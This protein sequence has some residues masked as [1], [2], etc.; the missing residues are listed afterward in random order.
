MSSIIISSD[1]PAVSVQI[2]KQ[3]VETLEYDYLSTPFLTQVAEKFQISE[4]ELMNCVDRPFSGRRKDLKKQELYLNYIRSVVLERLE[5]DHLVCQGLF[6]HLYVRLI[7]HILTVRVLSD[8][9]QRVHK[10]AEKENCS[11][12]RAERSLEKMDGDQRRWLQTIFGIDESDSSIYD[13]VFS[14]RS[15]DIDRVVTTINNTIQDR[16]YQAM[17]Y[18]R[19]C[20]RDLV[21][22]SHVRLALL[23]DYPDTGVK[24]TNGS[25]VLQMKGFFTNRRRKVAEVKKLVEPVSGVEFVEVRW[26]KML[27][28]D[29]NV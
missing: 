23:Q 26:N 17:T 16:R 1:D 21:I 2:A 6:A 14:L 13:I 27:S 8:P 29:A 9:M 10:Y 19:K 3:C 25:V 24:V 15:V 7:P 4:Q 18:S 22:G 28:G 20:L 5:Q 11:I 12:A